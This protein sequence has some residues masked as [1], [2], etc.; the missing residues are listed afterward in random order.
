[1]GGGWLR[2]TRDAPLADA[3]PVGLDVRREGTWIGVL[4]AVATFWIVVVQWHDGITAL[5]AL[6][7]ILSLRIPPG[8]R[9]AESSYARI[10]IG[11]ICNVMGAA[12]VGALALQVKFALAT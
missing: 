10:Y 2:T 11:T 12:A 1:M 6:K 7:A 8:A 9:H 4:E 5:V 3:Q